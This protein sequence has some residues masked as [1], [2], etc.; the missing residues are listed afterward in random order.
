MNRCLVGRREHGDGGLDVNRCRNRTV[1]NGPSL[2]IENTSSL[3]NPDAGG[4]TEPNVR[5]M[6]SPDL[7][8]WSTITWTARS[9]A[10]PRFPLV[11]VD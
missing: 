5:P 3:I 6:Q 4:G 10:L 11:R 1:H 7:S 2:T 9:A 8:D